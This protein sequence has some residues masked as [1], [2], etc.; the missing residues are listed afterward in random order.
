MN[1]RPFIRIFF[2]VSFS[3]S[4]SLSQSLCDGNLGENIFTQGDFGSGQENIVTKDPGI[5]PGY[6]YTTM[7]PPPD[8]FYTIT[9]NMGLW[10]NN[11]GTW[12]SFSDRSADPNGYMM[13][14][15]ASYTP[16]TFYEETISGLCANTVYEFSADILNIVTRSAQNH[17]LPEIE[18]LIND[19]L[20]YATGKIPQDETWRRYGFSFTLKP[21]ETEIK[22]TL[23]NRAP[24]G[25]GN[26]L[27]LDNI[28]FR[29][30]GG[31]IE[32]KTDTEMPLIYCQNQLEP[33]KLYTDID[34][35]QWYFQWQ[36]SNQING[37][38]ENLG[39][40]NQKEILH[41]SPNIG[42]YY[43]RIISATTPTN[44]NHPKCR[45]ESDIQVI[46]TPA[47]EYNVRDT[48]CQGT[49]YK[50]DNQS[51]TQPGQYNAMFTST[52]GCDS[53]V[54]L[55]L[56]E[57]VEKPVMPTW[58]PMD[59]LCHNEKSGSITLAEISGGYPPYQFQLQPDF[60]SSV[61]IFEQLSH[62]EY[63]VTTIDRHGCFHTSDLTLSN[64]APLIVHGPKDTSLI[65]GSQ[66]PIVIQS[67]HPVSTIE[68][69][70]VHDIPCANCEKFTLLPVHSETLSYRLT[71][72]KGC[73]FRSSFDIDVD[74]S[75]IPI[76]IPNAFT[77]NDDRHNDYFQ[78]IIPNNLVQNILNFQIFDRWGNLLYDVIQSKNALNPIGWDG[79]INEQPAATG[80]Y[81]YYIQLELIDGKQYSYTGTIQLV[82]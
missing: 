9:N 12:G 19:E 67:N 58:V 25:S 11:Y 14:V 38:W 55:T 82:R 47:V 39:N 34:T 48:F 81:L 32:V 53:L 17:S 59:P 4:L 65:F 13:V 18:F 42:Q 63:Q 36:F 50:F 31:V 43:Y 54:F 62:G 71:T 76:G 30:C 80:L 21:D 44:L 66:L 49:S 52:L 27:A 37:Q 29:P 79:N 28:S 8:G 60:P 20:K 26:D 10:N 64:P 45:T 23:V 51:L 41:T 3:Y 5:A 68:W 6:T 22:L 15:N 70:T 72:D 57:V 16:G 1:I 35:N 46:S 75:K 73:V 61:P 78:F 69:D 7:T 33:I 24:G 74:K 56:E 77:P 2:I 40:L